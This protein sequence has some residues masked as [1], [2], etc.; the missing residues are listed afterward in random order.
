MLQGCGPGLALCVSSFI[1]FS[2]LSQ[3]TGHQPGND[4]VTL[5]LTHSC[6][7]KLMTRYMERF[8]FLTFKNYETI[9]TIDCTI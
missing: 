7:C 6:F 8:L 2:A 4:A 5:P 3:M 1:Q 9:H